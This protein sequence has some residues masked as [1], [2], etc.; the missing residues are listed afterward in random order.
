MTLFK[1]EMARQGII[2]PKS[3]MHLPTQHESVDD[4][5]I[6]DEHVLDPDSRMTDGTIREEGAVGISL[7]RGS[8][9]EHNAKA[10][11]HLLS[12]ISD[13]LAPFFQC[14]CFALCM[15]PDSQILTSSYHQT[16]G[17]QTQPRLSAKKKYYERICRYCKGHGKPFALS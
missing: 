11:K 6:R 10:L 8:A 15:C 4:D 17:C 3:N 13:S 5:T 7:R 1:A 16:P 12:G 9:R 2:L 14:L